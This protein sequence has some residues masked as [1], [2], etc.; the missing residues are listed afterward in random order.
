MTSHHAVL[1]LAFGGHDTAAALLVD[2]RL[3]AACEQERYTRDKHSR[4]FPNDAV[5][6]CLKIGGLA[7]GDL[8]EIAVGMDMI[9]L[10]RETYLRPALTDDERLAMLIADVD[11]V[12]T[13]VHVDDQIRK[14]TGFAG[15]VRQYR[16]HRCHLASSYYP[17]GFD[18]A[19]IVSYDGMG[20]IDTGMI[21]RGRRGH[22]E[23]LFDGNH[24][25]DSLGLFYAA[26]THF[27]GW[28]YS[29]D[30]GIVMGLA[31]YGDPCAAIPGQSRSYLSVFRE[32][33]RT[34]GDYSYEVDRSWIAYHKERNKWV[35][36]KFMACFGPKRR[37]DEPVTT[38]HQHIAAALQRRL[39]EVVLGQLAKAREAYGLARLCLSGGVALNC[40]M[41]GKIIDSGLF[42]EIFVQ[43]ASGDPGTAIGACYLSY[44]ERAGGLAP[45][46][47]HDFYLGSRF[48]PDDIRQALERSGLSYRTPDD[49]FA[50]TAAKLAEGKIVGWFSGPAEF[51]PR[52]LGNRSILTRPYPGGMKDYLNERVKFREGFRPYAPAVLAERAPDYFEIHQESPHMLIAAQVRPEK[53][54]AIPAVVHVDGTCRVQTVT[55]SSNPRF[56]RLLEA[57]E[58]QTGCPV[59]LNTSFN[60]KG[61]P[62]VNSPDHAIECFLGT[63]LDVL[64]IGDF[65]CERPR[66]R[67][68]SRTAIES[69]TKAVVSVCNRGEVT[70]E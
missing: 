29:C 8:T 52:A 42:D 44:A 68:Q 23:D 22:I 38:H 67:G 57:F 12:R 3:V 16:H 65:Y 69:G 47:N 63:N 13:Y 11:R 17:S 62:I 7:T 31:P 39:E 54:E 51:G 53:R 49:M 32:I 25:P 70:A 55:A 18:E 4:L 64:V 27:L 59:L 10:V 35:S 48:T 20:E 45:M 24:Y 33:V 5:A 21:A 66:K 15:A 6:D 46:K 30:E 14:E 60:V 56:R 61:Q 34:T 28:K 9:R 41:N 43:P 19:L 58:R 1:G 40:S 26:V 36:D 2:G 37:P 50:L